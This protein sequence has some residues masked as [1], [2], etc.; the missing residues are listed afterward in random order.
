[1]EKKEYDK[2]CLFCNFVSGN[3]KTPWIFWEDDE[4]MAFL[5]IFPNTEWVTVVIPKKHLSSDV[6]SLADDY[7]QKFIVAAK[8]VAK[9]LTDKFDDVWRVGLVM[10]WTWINH[11]HIKLYPMHW[12]EFLKDWNWKAVESSNNTT[13]FFETYPWYISSVDGDI[14][15]DEIIRKL[16]NKLKS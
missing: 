9:I 10:E 12:T 15:N 4:F 7:L 1:M 3:I 8:K 6:L 14:V 11:A 2:D 16:A 5:T 13:P